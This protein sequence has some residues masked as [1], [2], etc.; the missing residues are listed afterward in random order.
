LVAAIL[1]SPIGVILG[2]IARGQIKQSGEGGDGL[3][4]AAIIIGAVFLL[5]SVLLFAGGALVSN[6]TPGSGY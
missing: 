3:A 5:I 6:S 2:V 1:C 4:L